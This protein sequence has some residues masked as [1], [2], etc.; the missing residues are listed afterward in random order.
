MVLAILRCADDHA[1]AWHYI[2]LGKPVQND[3]P[4]SLIGRVRDELLTRRCSARSC[5]HV[6]TIREA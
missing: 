1:V 3:V 4:E 6:R 2:V 5:T